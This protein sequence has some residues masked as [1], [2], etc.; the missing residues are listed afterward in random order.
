M[1]ERTTP[2]APTALRGAAM[3]LADAIPGVS[4]GT[5]ALILGIHPRLVAAIAGLGPQLVKDTFSDRRAEA[6]KRADI[7]FIALLGAGIAIGIV[8][9]A[10]ILSVVMERYPAALMAVLFGLV[11]ASIP[12]PAAVPKWNT[13]D[14]I[15]AVLAAV[16]AFSIAVV[17]SIVAPSGMWFL[18][19][20][21]A[22]AACAMILPGISGSYLLVLMGLYAS[23]I[24]AVAQLNLLIIALVGIGAVAGLMLFS[25]G[26][27]R[28][29]QVHP[30]RTH[31]AMVG[32]LAGSL[33]KL[34]PWRD[35]AGF[36][37][38]SPIAPVAVLP[39]VFVAIGLVLGVGLGRLPRTQT[40]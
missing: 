26:L 29:L 7:P 39:Y 10:N 2:P 4:G 14:I 23:V 37:E 40:A 34:W 31:A 28:M 38:G 9:G 35:T 21:G 16:L 18:P 30:G 12:I 13:G 15:S 5:M 36:A 25:R 32:L 3:G 22:I 33:V 19:I 17:P 6:W 1:D 24:D 20:A 11:A 27:R 8:I